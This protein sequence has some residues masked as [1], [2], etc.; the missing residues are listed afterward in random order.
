MLR[1]KNITSKLIIL[2]AWI[3][4]TCMSSGCRTVNNDTSKTKFYGAD[5]QSGEIQFQAYID[6]QI[7]KGVSTK[8]QLFKE[9]HRADVLKLIDRQLQ[10]LFGTFSVHETFVNNPGILETKGSPELLAATFDGATKIA[11][12]TYSYSDRVV[13]KKKVFRG[14]NPTIK[15]LMPRDPTTVYTK[16][17]GANGRNPCTDETYNSE[18][19]FWYFWNPSNEGCHIPKSELQEVTAKLF[20][21]ANTKKTY[22]DYEKILGDNQNGRLVKVVFLVGIDETFHRGDLGLKA[23]KEASELLVKQGFKMAKSGSKQNQLTLK[24]DKYDVEIDMRLVDPDESEFLNLAAAGLETADIFIYDGHSGLGSYM[25]LSR[26]EK[27]LGRP[28]KLPLNKSQIFYFNGC[29]TFPYYNEVYFALKRTTDDPVGSRHLD[30]ITTSVGATFDV[31][32]RHDS[33]FL[34]GLLLGKYPTWQKILDEIYE[35]DP[36]ESTL[37]HVNGDEDNPTASLGI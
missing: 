27:H 23:Y 12:V 35:V 24:R 37:S 20:P 15:F 2:T 13:F 21:K 18:E 7:P 36:A 31:G 5:N 30:I 14:D 32:A 8:E 3:G 33:A 19:D 22:P 10:H 29:S 34:G 25:N 6:L 1:L 26:F 17:L 9:P 4:F 28:L 16:S 11:R